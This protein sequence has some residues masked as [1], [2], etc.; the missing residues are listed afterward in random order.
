MAWD[1]D[2]LKLSVY[3]PR[4]LEEKLREEAEAA[5]VTPSRLIRLSCF[6]GQPAAA[7]VSHAQ[8]VICPTD[9]PARAQ[10]GGWSSSRKRLHPV[11]LGADKRRFGL[12]RRA[13]R[14]ISHSLSVAYGSRRNLR[15]ERTADA[16]RSA[17]EP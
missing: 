9:D 8:E 14:T 1:S 16:A 7:S 17:G 13:A 4:R 11:L 2:A 5:E 12:S 10:F 3:V 6:R 15:L